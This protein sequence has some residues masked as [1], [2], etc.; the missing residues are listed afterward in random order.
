M[1]AP[2]RQTLSPIAKPL[3]ETLQRCG[4]HKKGTRLIAAVSGG[5]DSVAML[6]TLASLAP[7]HK[8]TVS[9]AHLNHGIR[10]SSEQDA[11]FV[12]QLCDQLGITLTLEHRDVPQLAK[13]SGKSIEMAAR[14][15]RYAFFKRLAIKEKA[16][17]VL[18]AHTLNDQSETVLLNLSRGT[19]TAGLGGIPFD[20][21]ANGFRV[22]RPLLWVPRNLIELTL[23][24]LEQDWREDAS[25]QDMQYRRNAV[26]HQLLPLMKNVLNPNTIQAIARTALLAHDDNAMIEQMTHHCCAD[27]LVSSKKADFPILRLAPFRHQPTPIR[28]RLLCWWL[29][30]IGISPEQ[31]RFE[32]IERI[33]TLSQQHSG[34]GKIQLTQNITILH[35]YDHLQCVGHDDTPL[36]E[37]SLVCPGTTELPDYDCRIVIALDKGYNREPILIPGSMPS[38]TYLRQPCPDEAYPFTVRSRRHGDRVQWLGERHTRKLK[39]IFI[40]AKIP[41]H[42]RDRIPLICVDGVIAWVPGCRPTTRFAVPAQDA[43]SFRISIMPN[44]PMA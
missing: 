20:R 35:A 41:K 40:D 2:N 12:E 22:V 44:H 3:F 5:A 31:R 39:S 6:V 18:T 38:V 42:Q 9:A 26:R 36:A 1:T 19:G 30:Q 34:G 11:H 7:H 4:L 37:Q 10:A 21:H 17:A 8:W 13:D 32:W 25:N 29:E 16:D 14:N 27:I 24:K 43:P 23:H 33:D 15:A 28:R